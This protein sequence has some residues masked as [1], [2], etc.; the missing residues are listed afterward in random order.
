MRDL[1]PADRSRAEALLDRQDSKNR[2]E[3]ERLLIK[4]GAKH[5]PRI[6]KILLR[7]GDL[8]PE[9][10]ERA[11]EGPPSAPQHQAAPTTAPSPEQQKQREQANRALGR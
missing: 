11:G 9:S 6:E 3:T 8:A 10:S 2:G 4:T 5:W 7:F 1:D